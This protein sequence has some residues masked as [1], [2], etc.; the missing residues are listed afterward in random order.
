MLH[1]DEIV[2]A[3]EVMDRKRSGDDLLYGLIKANTMHSPNAVSMFGQRRR[4]WANIET[5]LGECLVFAGIYY[6][7]YIRC[8]RVVLSEAVDGCICIT[9]KIQRGGD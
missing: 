2:I 8:S 5:A 3:V 6:M 1:R 7:K 9:R 4:R